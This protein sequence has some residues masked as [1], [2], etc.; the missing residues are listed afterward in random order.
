MSA[1]ECQRY[2][3][4]HAA[5]WVRAFAGM[6]D[7]VMLLGFQFPPRPSPEFHDSVKQFGPEMARKER[8]QGSEPAAFGVPWRAELRQNRRTQALVIPAFHTALGKCST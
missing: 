3:A 1:R 7:G 4:R 6:T 5:R 2:T 8:P